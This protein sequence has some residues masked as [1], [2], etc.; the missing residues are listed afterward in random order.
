VADHRLRISDRAHLIMPITDHTKS[1]SRKR[2]APANWTTAKA[3]ARRTKTRPQGEV[4]ASA[5]SES[6][7][8]A[9][10]VLRAGGGEEPAHG[11]LWLRAAGSGEVTGSLLNAAK[12]IVPL[13]SDVS[14]YLNSEMDAARACC[15]KAL[16]EPY[17]TLTTDLPLCDFL[18]RCG[19]RRLH[20]HRCRT[21]TDQCRGRCFQSVRHPRWR[22]RL[23]HGS[24]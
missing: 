16:R 24:L 8:V 10:E 20:W 7:A 21:H 19:R 11:A 13:I 15:L 3:S 17:W 12:K 5:I 14:L 9:T 18:Q 1:P 6:R 2:A 23:S 22:R 4:C